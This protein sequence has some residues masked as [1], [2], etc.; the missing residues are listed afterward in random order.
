MESI[1]PRVRVH[2]LS[3]RDQE[4]LEFLKGPSVHRIGWAYGQIVEAMSMELLGLHI[5][6]GAFSQWDGAAHEASIRD[7]LMVSRGPED[8]VAG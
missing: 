8:G 5:S 6:K 7:G 2:E 3:R 4:G 1:Q